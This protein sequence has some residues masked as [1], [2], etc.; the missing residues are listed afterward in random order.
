MR[1]LIVCNIISLDGFYSGAGGDLSAMPF[2]AGFSDYNV[3]RLRAADTLLLGRKTFEAFRAY[4]P[5]IADDAN[6]PAVEREVSR[7]NTAMDKV[8]VSDGPTPDQLKGWGPARVVKRANAQAEVAALKEEPGREILIFGSHVLWNDLLAAGL[9]DE[10]HL[11]IG[12]GIVCDGVR[13]FER[14]PPGSLRLLDARAFEG[15][16]LLLARYGVEG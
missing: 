16:S 9:V 1:K 12:A 13:A 8:V 3:E 14:R 2:D 7:L 6:Q 15:S 5:A 11:M 4:W 10:L